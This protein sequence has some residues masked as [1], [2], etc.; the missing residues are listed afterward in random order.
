M[1]NYFW[2][3]ISVPIDAVHEV[4]VT[5][6]LREYPT[7]PL[8]SAAGPGEAPHAAYGTTGPGLPNNG[9][10]LP[11]ALGKMNFVLFLR[12]RFD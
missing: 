8:R 3:A 7:N 4:S 10:P 9:E 6:M 5:F 11:T 1:Q 12:T 2:H